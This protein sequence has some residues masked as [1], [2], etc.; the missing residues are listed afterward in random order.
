[1]TFAPLDY[2]IVGVYAAA[3]VGIGVVT[4]RR[5]KREGVAENEDYMVAGR[6][7]TLPAFVATLVATWYGGILGVGEM[8]WGS[9]IG[10]WTCFGLPYYLYAVVYALFL[11][12]RVREA[13]TLTIPDKL[14]EAHGKPAALVGGALVFLL[15]TPAPYVLMLGTL[16]QGLFGWG[17][18]PA[19]LV[20][21]AVSV[22]FVVTGG[23]NTDVRT[24][25]LQFLLMFASFAV[26]L[27]FAAARHGGL[28]WVAATVPP[29]L[30][31]LSGG[32]PWA[33]ISVWYVLAL[34]TLI[35]PGFHQRVSAAKNA[36]TARNGILLSVLCWAVFDFMTV[37][38][39]M[40]ARAILP[41][42]KTAV[43]AYPAL[44]EAV[45][46]AG[47]KGLF[48]VGMLATV[49]S[50]VLSYTFLA[51]ITLGRD[52]VWRARL[53]RNADDVFWTRVGI[54]LTSVLSVAAALALPSV[55][56]LWY[57]FGAVFVPGL[58]LPLVTAYGPPR[59]RARPGFVVASMLAG[60]GIALTWLL[61]GAARGDG[62]AAPQYPFGVEALYAGLAAS[63]L[64]WVAGLLGRGQ[65]S[66]PVPGNPTA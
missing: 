14:E 13:R 25:I 21:T 2:G 36:R 10:T 17:V 63:V 20:G 38:C 37:T 42:L 35:D 5:R 11:A 41:D 60:S 26:L 30:R 19:L 12:H 62:L 29:E 27:G 58:L 6:T 47:W 18:L 51:A 23:F 59:L 61:I 9:G 34:Q 32:L 22:A 57:A 39:G 16:L 44:S 54:A 66:P 52:L 24:N 56:G 31:S 4:A 40:Y 53:S 33:Y 46:P 49:M 45:L 3:L 48:W 8:A 7:L 15:V 64:V 1:M 43:D 55:V 28:D 50:T 65:E